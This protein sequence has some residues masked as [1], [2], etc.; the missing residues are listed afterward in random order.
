MRF[1]MILS[2]VLCSVGLKAHEWTPTY[3]ELTQ[4]YVESVLV[5]EMELWNGRPDVEYYQINV[6]DSDW[7]P[8]PFAVAQRIIRVKYLSRASVNVYV[9]KSDSERVT[10]ICSK[11]KLVKD[12]GTKAL[13]ASRICSKIK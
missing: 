9:R 6:W 2:L 12:S 4:S 5:T 8:V 3:P 11:S 10:Y 7:N 1:V 13:I